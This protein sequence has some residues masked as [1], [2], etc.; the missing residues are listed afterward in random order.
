MVEGDGQWNQSGREECV[1]LGVGPGWG[2]CG[3][4]VGYQGLYPT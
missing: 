4:V 3:D 1:L 2:I